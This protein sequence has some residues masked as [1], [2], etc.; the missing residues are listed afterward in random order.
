MPGIRSSS[1]PAH[2]WRR[3]VVLLGVSLALSVLDAHGTIGALSGLR[4]TVAAMIGP[5]QTTAFNASKPVADFFADWAEVG[6]KNERIAVLQA[7]NDRLQRL[8]NANG[9]ANRRAAQ[10]DG[11]LQLAGLGKLRIV[12]ASVMSIGTAA[13]YGWTLLIDVGADDGVKRNMNVIAAGGLVGRVLNTTAH[14][15]TV[16][17]L[18]DPTAS[19]GARVE[20]SGEVGFVSGTGSANGLTLEFLDPASVVRVGERIVTFGVSGGVFLPGLPIGI[21]TAVESQTGTN[22]L[23]ARIRPFVDMSA[24]DLVGVVLNAPRT[25]PR[26]S[27]LPAATPV[28]T[29]TVTVTAS[30][31]A[32]GSKATISAS[33]SAP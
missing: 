9:D 4:N 20:N 13:G 1:P 18:V 29:V 32:S 22:S 24:L 7:S 5:V 8:V 21:V 33:G 26:D 11:L 6:S 15:A 14:T 31:S 28:P 16:V 10:L 2:P 30:P 12:P 25:D 17:M 27:L 23:V 3:L 19:V